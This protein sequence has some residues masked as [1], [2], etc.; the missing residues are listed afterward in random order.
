[1]SL[2]I[3]F[4]RA[5]KKFRGSIWR[6]LSLCVLLKLLFLVQVNSFIAF[7]SLVGILLNITFAEGRVCSRWRMIRYGSGR[8]SLRSRVGACVCSGLCLLFLMFATESLH[9]WKS[10]SGQPHFLNDGHVVVKAILTSGHNLNLSA[11]IHIFST[12]EA[13][14]LRLGNFYGI[15]EIFLWIYF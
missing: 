10:G 4:C 2:L 14:E 13:W 15:F 3:Y 8:Y 6:V 1:M 9:L 5:S 12:F 11:S 7:V